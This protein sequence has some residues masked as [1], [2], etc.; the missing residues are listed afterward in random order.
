MMREELCPHHGYWQLQ[1]GTLVP[2]YDVTFQVHCPQNPL[3]GMFENLRL[4][5]RYWYQLITGS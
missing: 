3:L 2:E 1:Q 4:L 5:M